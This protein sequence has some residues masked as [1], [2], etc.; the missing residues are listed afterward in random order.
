MDAYYLSKEDWDAIVE[1]G[2][3]EHKDEKVLKSIST[4]TKTAFTKRWCLF[5]LTGYDGLNDHFRYNAMDHPIAFHK[6]DDLSKAPRKL[7]AEQLPD[8]EEAFEVSMT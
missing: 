1:L 2:V 8:L 3:G 5:H 7:V 6:A 4:G